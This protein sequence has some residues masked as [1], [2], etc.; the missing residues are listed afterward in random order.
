MSP[1]PEMACPGRRMRAPQSTMGWRRQASA[2]KQRTEVFLAPVLRRHNIARYR[3]P[4]L[5]F[6]QRD[7]TVTSPAN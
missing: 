2:M 6:L 5:D 7:I 3:G 4:S 1:V